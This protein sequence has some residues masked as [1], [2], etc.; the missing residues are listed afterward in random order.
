MQ[1]EEGGVSLYTGT[2]IIGRSDNAGNEA[3]TLLYLE[4]NTEEQKTNNTWPDIQ[5]LKIERGIQ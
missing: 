3:F 4:N 2:L 5:T 1:Q